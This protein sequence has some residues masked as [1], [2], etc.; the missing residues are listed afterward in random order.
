MIVGATKPEQL[1]E[2]LESIDA[3]PL[4]D[5]AVKG[6]KS[7]GY[8]YGRGTSRQLSWLSRSGGSLY[9]VDKALLSC[10]DAPRL[11]DQVITS[12]IKFSSPGYW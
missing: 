12:W 9:H 10:V 6:S 11:F 8:G 1:E 7:V 4:P 3:G 2:T 5:S